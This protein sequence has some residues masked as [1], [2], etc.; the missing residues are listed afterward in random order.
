MQSPSPVPATTGHPPGAPAAGRQ[1]WLAT[2]NQYTSALDLAGATGGQARKN[3]T[4]TRRS[5]RL[6]GCCWWWTMR[7]VSCSVWCLWGG[8]AGEERAPARGRAQVV[9]RLRVGATVVGCLPASGVLSSLSRGMGARSRGVAA[10]GVVGAGGAML[11]LRRVCVCVQNVHLEDVILPVECG[12]GRQ[13]LKWLATVSCTRYGL[14][15]SESRTQRLPPL[16]ART[17][18]HPRP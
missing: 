13:K 10:E 16:R 18:H 2:A 6:R 11:T 7:I 8:E 9:A 1:E 17:S 15:Q 5:S 4:R 12:E 14:L 3:G